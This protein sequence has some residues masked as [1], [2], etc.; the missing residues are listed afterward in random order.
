MTLRARMLLAIG[1]VLMIVLIGALFFIVDFQDNQA[2]QLF[3][4]Q[5]KS[6]SDNF[7][8]IRTIVSEHGGIF[9]KE[10]PGSGPNPY[11]KNNPN[12]KPEITTAKG[13]KLALI[14]GFTFLDELSALSK[15]TK[16]G[17]FGF[18]VPSDIPLNPANKANST[19]Q[20]ILN[21]M[22]AQGLAEYFGKAKDAS[23]KSVYMYNSAMVSQQACIT[24]HPN[25]KL[26]QVVG[27]LS[28][29]LPIAQIEAQQRNSMN[30][31]IYIFLGILVVISG[32]IYWLTGHITAPINELA[33]ITNRISNGELNVKID[34]KRNDEIG[35]L[36]TAFNR[37]VGE[38][39]H[40]QEELKSLY[41]DVVKAFVRAIEAKDTYTRGHSE[42]VA[43]YAMLLGQ[44]LSLSNEQMNELE[45]AALLH[46][47]GKIGIR[48]EI[49]NKPGSLTAAEYEHIKAHPD[50]SAQIVGSI[51]NLAPITDIIKHHHERYD[52][53]GYIDGLKGEQIPFLS[54]ILALADT[55]DA[56]TSDRPYRRG[57]DKER[58]FAELREC[59]G[60]QFDPDLVEPF[61]KAVA[62]IEIAHTI[63]ESAPIH[64]EQ[65]KPA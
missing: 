51:P 58:A 21:K 55:F 9:A 12:I 6:I 42:N 29:S 3:Y 18:K 34:I 45:I 11:L 49:L 60:A 30:Q 53:R 61:I 56:M 22:R 52:G 26:G 37:M 2:N 47:V 7:A 1:P 40:S 44:E 27:M 14:S 54:R 24:C 23:G 10:E 46:D 57:C 50:I 48:E 28:I 59:A 25:Y 35:D 65:R 43:K 4:D 16:V 38:V 17:T 36:A 13:E 15:R 64:P 8:L 63:D 33:S 41:L 39:N 19:E 62:D 32:L 31:T 20:R 5:A